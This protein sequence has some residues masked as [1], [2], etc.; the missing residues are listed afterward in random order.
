[1][2]IRQIKFVA[3]A[4]DGDV[5]KTT[6]LLERIARVKGATA[7]KHSVRE[8]DDEDSI[9]LEPFRLMHRGKIDRLF[10]G[11]LIRGRFR[12]DITNQR[13]LR[14]EFIYVFELTCKCRELV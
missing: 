1:M 9:K 8:P 11:R 10:I 13:Q 3:R 7:W 6:L 14:K 4:R 12:I 5:K 2:G